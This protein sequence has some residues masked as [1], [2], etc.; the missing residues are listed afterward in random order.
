MH[1]SRISIWFFIGLLLV[2]YG[3]MILGAGLTEW[4]TAS[5]P[6]GVELNQLH[7]PIWWGGMLEILGLFYVINFR[8]GKAAK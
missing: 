8:P 1:G 2:V 4:A 3:A 7:A 6:A 5:Y